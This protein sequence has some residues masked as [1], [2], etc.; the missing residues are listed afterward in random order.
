MGFQTL[1]MPPYQS[2]PAGELYCQ[3]HGKLK[4]PGKAHNIRLSG[5]RYKNSLPI[6]RAVFVSMPGKPDTMGLSG[7]FLF[8]V[9]LAIHLASGPAL[10]MAAW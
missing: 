6:W 7:L 4:K 2:Q 8:S 9:S 1:T 10:G 3:D 5:H